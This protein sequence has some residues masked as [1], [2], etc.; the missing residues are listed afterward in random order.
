MVGSL[1]S[2][3]TILTARF[4]Y[5]GSNVGIGGDETGDLLQCPF[6]TD[7]FILASCFLSSRHISFQYLILDCVHQHRILQVS[8]KVN[9]GE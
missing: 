2:K 9:G 5:L 3:C 1:V 8:A 7:W 4:P 6:D